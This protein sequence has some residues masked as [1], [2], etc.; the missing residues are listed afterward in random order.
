MLLHGVTRLDV[1]VVGLKWGSG[2]SSQ[3]GFPRIIS[4]LVFAINKVLS[5]WNAKCEYYN[6]TSIA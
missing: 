4:E 5:I 3:Y 6:H 1:V 2:V